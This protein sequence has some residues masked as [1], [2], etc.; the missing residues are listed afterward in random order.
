MSKKTSDTAEGTIRF[1]AGAESDDFTQGQ[2]AGTGWGAY[3]DA[4]GNA[5]LE[6]DRVIVRKTLE[7]AELLINQISF[8]LGDTV[9]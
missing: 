6:A 5:V 9:F 7:A 2:F 4:N 1:K 3:K 8:T